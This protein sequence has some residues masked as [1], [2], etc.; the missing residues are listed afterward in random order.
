MK[1]H[2]TVI[3]SDKTIIVDGIALP[4]DF[5]APSSLHALQWHNGEGELEIIE[6]GRMTNQAIASYT[7]EVKPYVD[8]WQTKYDEINT[9][10]VPTLEE[11]KE[12]K[13]AELTSA[14]DTAAQ[15]AHL[16]SSVG[17]EIDANEVANRN[18]EGLTLVMS[19]TDTTL[20]CDY[21]NQFHEVTRAQLET[22]RREIVANSQRLYQIK[23]QYRSLIEAATTVDE[24][25]AITITFGEA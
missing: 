11:A 8:I 25:D 6:N 17:F 13:L 3:P 9:P 23:W 21:N 4:C 10:Y 15:N 22:M 5:E 19:D 2:V 16:M 20:F 24:L 14:F 1:E 18:I 7:S 12:A